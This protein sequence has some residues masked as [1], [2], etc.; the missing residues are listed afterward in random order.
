MKQILAILLIAAIACST[1]PEE[2]IIQMTNDIANKTKEIDE[3]ARALAEEIVEKAKKMAEEMAKK[4]TEQG[5]ASAQR[6]Q[7]I[8]QELDAN[9]K[10][11][12]KDFLKF[13]DKLNDEAKMALIWLAENGYLEKLISLAELLGKGAASKLCQTYLKQSQDS[14]DKVVQFLYDNVIGLYNK[15]KNVEQV[16]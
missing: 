2:E 14:C 7:E 12:I 1:D 16:K 9:T 4:A 11:L 6:A 5:E 10:E 3:K 13:F 15:A 8:A